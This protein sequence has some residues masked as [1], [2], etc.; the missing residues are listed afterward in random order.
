MYE[1]IYKKELNSNVTLMRVNA[2]LVAAKAEPGQFIIL[3]TDSEGERIPLTIA[4]F[5]REKGYVTVIFQVVGATTKKLNAMRE[6]DSLDCF[7]G[8]LG[9]ATETDGLKKVAIIGGG[10][11]CAIALP[12]A[13]KLHKKGCHVD[14]IVG[15]RNKEL[16]I[17]FYI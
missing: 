13:E 5:D 8:P 9:R 14:A 6:G 3:R 4:D 15:F 7:V 2:P 10:V 12:V 16:V 17:L 1:I 11:G